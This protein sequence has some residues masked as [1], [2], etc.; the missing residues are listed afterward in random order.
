MPIKEI[1]LDGSKSII[2]STAKVYHIKIDSDD[3]DE[4]GAE[5]TKCWAGTVDFTHCFNSFFQI[6]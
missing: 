1:G 3:L 6:N 2:M 5:Q 4:C